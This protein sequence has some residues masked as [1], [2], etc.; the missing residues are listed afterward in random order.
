[1]TSSLTKMSLLLVLLST[2][3]CQG[4]VA[5]QGSTKKPKTPTQAPTA[6]WVTARYVSGP[7]GFG[8][9]TYYTPRWTR[10]PQQWGVPMSYAGKVTLYDRNGWA[11]GTRTYTALAGETAKTDMWHKLDGKFIDNR[12]Y[13]LIFELA[14]IRADGAIYT[15]QR[16]TIYY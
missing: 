1:M 3:F 8:G 15:Y 14:A 12:G 2:L 7:I 16:S 6:H 4:V 13:R 10:P 5:Q 11:W 9:S